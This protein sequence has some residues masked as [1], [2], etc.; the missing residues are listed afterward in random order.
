MT[1]TVST[2][3]RTR[4]PVCSRIVQVQLDYVNHQFQVF[5]LAQLHRIGRFL[6]AVRTD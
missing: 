4:T 1:T 3:E 5:P 2:G 6:N